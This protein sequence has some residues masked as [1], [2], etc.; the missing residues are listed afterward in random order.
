M[1]SNDDFRKLL[2]PRPPPA[3]R[4]QPYPPRTPRHEVQRHPANF[5]VQ[6]W[7]AWVLRRTLAERPASLRESACFRPVPTARRGAV[8]GRSTP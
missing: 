3:A 2:A 4:P 5:E 7:A 8:F 1:L 6:E